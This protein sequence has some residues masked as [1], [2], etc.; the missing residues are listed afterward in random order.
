[1]EFPIKSWSYMLGAFVAA[2][3]TP[4]TLTAAP[5]GECKDM[6]R[7]C[8]Y[9]ADTGE[10]NRHRGYMHV[11][12]MAS[13]KLCSRSKDTKCRDKFPD[14]NSITS[15][16]E[17]MLNVSR[18]LDDCPET[19][20]ICG[21]GDPC[22]VNQ[23]D[24]GILGDSGELDAN[25]RRIASDPLFQDYGV[26]VL[27]KD[28]WLIVFDHFLSNGEADRFR[29]QFDGQW[30]RSE[31]GGIY[32]E[33]EVSQTR[34]SDHIWCRTGA[35][36]GTAIMQL[37]L[38]RI[39]NISGVPPTNYEDVQMLR[40]MKGQQYTEHNDFMRKQTR[41]SCG[42]RLM[43]FFV[44]LSDVPEA[45]TKFSVLNHTVPAQKG[46]AALWANVQSGNTFQVDM[47]TRHAGL[48]PRGDAIKYS[49]NVW[50][51]R[52]DFQA[53]NALGCFNTERD[54]IHRRTSLPRRSETVTAEEL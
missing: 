22:R 5:E 20:S 19:C 29:E 35:C 18:M 48:P 44:Y 53:F 38:Q 30:E 15:A 51:H 39:E 43:T 54:L 23:D 17:C 11:N 10:C 12:C 2:I 16:G 6:S 25:F 42:P 28:P 32:G 1:M 24:R 45:G 46:R 13:C 47:R 52:W 21:P 27:S 4:M 49:A 41:F 50:I 9:W 34:T 33:G 14:C 36:R 26:K 31:S 3:A 7:N 40:Y 8:K 37:F